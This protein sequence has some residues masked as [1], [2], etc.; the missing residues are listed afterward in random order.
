MV[1]HYVGIDIALKTAA[2]AWQVSPDASP[3]V[4]EIEQNRQGYKTLLQHL[5]TLNQPEQIQVVMEAT[6]TYWMDLAYTLYETGFQVS[7]V[8]PSQPKYFAKM[9]LQRSKTDAIDAV[10]LMEYA[11]SQHPALW[12]PPPA[13]CEQLRQYLTYRQQLIEI[14]TQVRNQYHALKQNPKANP[15]ILAR[16]QQRLEALRA[17]IKQ[18]AQAIDALLASEHDWT[19]AVHFLMSIPGI[20]TITTAWLLVATH[21]FERC[22]TPQQAVAFAGLA[23]HP[24][25]SGSSINGYRSIGGAGHRPLRNTL[26]MASAPASRFNPILK[27]FYNKLLARGKPKKLARCAVARKLIHMAWACVTKKRYFDPDFQQHLPVA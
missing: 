5:K 23:P 4:I 6:S 3:T 19:D 8:N 18:L 10:L 24:K 15:D 20:S 25:Q 2:V 16:M 21:A 17:E 14:Q 9:R 13:I 22:E 12:T 7:V 1:R 11:Q 26:Y 27:A